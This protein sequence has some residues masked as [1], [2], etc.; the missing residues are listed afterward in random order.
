MKK[1]DEINSKDNTILLKQEINHEN[2]LAFFAHMALGKM[3]WQGTGAQ[4][5]TVKKPAA[6]LK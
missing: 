4:E 2:W 6:I 5:C 3:K 1:P